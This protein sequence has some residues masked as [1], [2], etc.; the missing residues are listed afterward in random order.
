MDPDFNIVCTE[1][2]VRNFEKNK[3]KLKLYRQ[4]SLQKEAADSPKSEKDI[5][6]PMPFHNSCNICRVQYT[7]F[8]EHKKSK[9][10]QAIIELNSKAYTIIDK[11]LE[12]IKVCKTITIEQ[13][14][15]DQNQLLIP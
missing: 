14:Q 1:A 15:E 13:T 9:D 10:H 5:Q 3:D 7:N 12:I 6:E 11:E 2:E 8:E 4:R